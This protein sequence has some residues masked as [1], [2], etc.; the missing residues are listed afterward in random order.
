[1][2]TMVAFSISKDVL[3][4]SFA[5]KGWKSTRDLANMFFIFILLFIAIATILQLSSYGAKALLAK[6]II[7]ALLINFSLFITRVIIDSGNITAMFFYDA[8]TVPPSTTVPKGVAI[9]G[10]EIKSLSAGLVTKVHLQ[11]R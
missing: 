10:V 11:K 7:F 5:Q 1:M 3:N 6:L 4:A 2:D 9:P 8:I